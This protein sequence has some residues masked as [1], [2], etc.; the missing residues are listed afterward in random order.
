V[1]GRK[2]R[3]RRP[4][5]GSR[6]VGA[7]QEEPDKDGLDE[8]CG[9]SASGEVGAALCCPLTP[10]ISVVTLALVPCR[11]MVMMLAGLQA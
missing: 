1:Q 6:E 2:E 5:R 7:I 11:R 3:R 4:R 9:S 10:A 8:P